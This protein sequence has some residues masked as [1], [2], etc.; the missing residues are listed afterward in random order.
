M[1]FARSSVYAIR[2]LV[3]LAQQPDP[4][5]PVLL[6]DIASSCGL[7]EGFISKVFQ[8]MAPWHIVESHRGRRRGY[9][10]GRR[11]ANIS[12]YDIVVAAEGPG[13]FNTTVPD[14]LP[15]NAEDMVRRAWKQLDDTVARTLRALTLE[16]LTNGI[17]GRTHEEA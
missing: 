13:L 2:G 8:R 3:Y 9:S 5:E 15:S 7:P 12:L 10:L 4:S 1:R 17:Q 16:Q 11:P 6:R 14:G